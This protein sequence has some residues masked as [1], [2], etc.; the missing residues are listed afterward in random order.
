MR[1]KPLLEKSALGPTS[2]GSGI[3]LPQCQIS[4]YDAARTDPTLCPGACQGPFVSCRPVLSK[5]RI[6]LPGWPQADSR[7][8]RTLP[9]CT[10]MFSHAVPSRR[11]ICRRTNLSFVETRVDQFLIRD[12]NFLA[13]SDRGS[14]RQ[15]CCCDQ[16]LASTGSSLTIFSLESINDVCH[17]TSI[18][19]II[20]T[21]HRLWNRCHLPPGTRFSAAS[22][23]TNFRSSSTPFEHA[24]ASS[25]KCQAHPSL[26][27]NRI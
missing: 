10:Q 9:V 2:S 12:R 7:T 14:K 4:S 1:E 26:R 17:V 11:L 15:A 5:R 16:R 24:H 21:M 25:P 19:P 3:P 6:Q 27:K 22:P 18:I 20:S 8:L 13:A 23:G